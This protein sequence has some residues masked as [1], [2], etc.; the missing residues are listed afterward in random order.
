LTDPEVGKK[1]RCAESLNPTA[2][3]L[4]LSRGPG[5]RL[6]TWGSRRALLGVVSRKEEKEK[7]DKKKENEYCLSSSSL[8]FLQPKY[9]GGIGRVQGGG[10]PDS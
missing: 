3:E 10:E 7:K 1:S 5:Q 8:E 9:I 4:D 6:A 2:R